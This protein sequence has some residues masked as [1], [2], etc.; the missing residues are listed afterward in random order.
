[1]NKKFKSHF[2]NNREICFIVL[3][4]NLSETIN[5]VSVNEHHFYLKLSDTST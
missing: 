1:M 3:F 2:Q 4:Q 5:D